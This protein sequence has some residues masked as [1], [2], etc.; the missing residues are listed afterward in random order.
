MTLRLMYSARQPSAFAFCLGRTQA[1]ATGRG[2]ECES[3]AGAQDAQQTRL[4][5][6]G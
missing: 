1:P 2:V 5:K 4:S 6:R 3:L